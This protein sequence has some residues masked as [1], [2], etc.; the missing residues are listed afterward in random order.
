MT[1][2]A[3]YTRIQSLKSVQMRCA[4]I[5]SDGGSG[6]EENLLGAAV[7]VIAS[8]TEH[9]SLWAVWVVTQHRNSSNGDISNTRDF[10]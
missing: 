10:L 1:S 5:C 8:I 4:R 3:K 7:V 9:H 6:G 2:S